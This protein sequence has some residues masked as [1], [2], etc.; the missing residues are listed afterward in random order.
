VAGFSPSVSSARGRPFGGASC[1]SGQIAMLCSWQEPPASVLVVEAEAAG[2]LSREA[3]KP[4]TAPLINEIR[5][6]RQQRDLSKAADRLD[7]SGT[8]DELRE[9][10]L[11]EF[12]PMAEK[13]VAGRCAARRSTASSSERPPSILDQQLG[14][15]GQT[16]R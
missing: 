8:K 11:A 9:K 7:A 4:L 16:E 15:P 13:V 2:D 12:W 14:K 1:L 10:M 3:P 5:Q 6:T